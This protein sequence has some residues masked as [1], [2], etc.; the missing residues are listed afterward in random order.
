MK[1][2]SVVTISYNNFEG[3]KKTVESVCKQTAFEQIEYVIIDGASTDGTRKYLEALPETIKWISEPDRG[4]S[5]AFNKGIEKTTG[6]YILCLNSGDAFVDNNVIE[7]V[8]KDMV[9]TS[10]DIISYKVRV[11]DNL[12]IPSID[13]EDKIRTRCEEPHQGTFVRRKVYEEIGGYSEEY[14]IRMD[15]HFFARCMK[16]GCSYKYI[17]DPWIQTSV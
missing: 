12:F 9:N 11:T 15:Y 2:I 6:E 13:D 16:K 8:L 10:A 17:M 1:K 14:K 4:I 3:L 7:N 5:H